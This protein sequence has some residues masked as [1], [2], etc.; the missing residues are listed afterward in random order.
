[1]DMRFNHKNVIRTNIPFYSNI[2]SCC[3]SHS[4]K[5]E[6][7]FE[8]T[9]PYNTEINMYTPKNTYQHFVETEIVRNS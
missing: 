5:I 2:V 9:S 1:M 7:R 4:T 6:E 3:M 8:T